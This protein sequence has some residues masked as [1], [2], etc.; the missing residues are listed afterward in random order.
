MMTATQMN[1]RF[2]ENLKK[3][4]ETLVKRANEFFEAQEEKII[5]AVDNFKGRVV[6]KEI[7]ADITSKV[8]ELFLAHDYRVIDLNNT[9]IEVIWRG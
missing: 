1:E 4:E 9:A 5:E 3:R 6:I 8:A 7:P 2:E